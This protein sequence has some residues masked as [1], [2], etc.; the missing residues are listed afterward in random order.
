MSGKRITEAK[1]T[2]AHREST[3]E[4]IRNTQIVN[5]LIAHAMGE[6]DMSASQVAAAKTLLDR[7][8]PIMKSVEMEAEVSTRKPTADPYFTADPEE[9][10][11][12]AG[13]H[14]PAH[15]TH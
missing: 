5:R 9:W 4:R 2:K 8:L 3:I 10:R 7:Y 13:D 6:I 12:S 14:N 1:S 15:S 11:K